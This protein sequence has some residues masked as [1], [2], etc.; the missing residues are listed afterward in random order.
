MRQPAA[1]SEQDV[2]GRRKLRLLFVTWR[3]VAKLSQ[4]ALADR[5]GVSY[6]TVRALESPRSLEP[7][8]FVVAHVAAAIQGRL[9]E[10]DET[11]LGE[12]RADFLGCLVPADI[13]SPG[14]PRSPETLT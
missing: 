10:L 12:F 2:K 6:S 7:G 8:F 9:A 11:L 14:T 5:A 3:K 1:M 13:P 4:Q